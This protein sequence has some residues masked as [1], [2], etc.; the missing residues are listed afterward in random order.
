MS[1]RVL[2]T[3]DNAILAL[4]LEDWL[5]QKG[6][7]VRLLSSGI[8]FLQTISEFRP[9]VVLLDLKLPDCFGLDLLREL[10]S[11]TLASTPVVVLSAFTLSTYQQQAKALG[12]EDFLCKP[13][14]Y[15]Q[16]EAALQHSIQ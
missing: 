6:F 8:N 4:D 10:R 13:V 16:I 12:V 3:E 15:E 2:L 9:D 7:E 11:S 5:T 1:H 14:S